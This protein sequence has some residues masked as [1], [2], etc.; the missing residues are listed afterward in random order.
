M[1]LTTFLITT[2]IIFAAPAMAQDAAPQTPPAQG[3]QADKPKGGGDS[4]GRPRRPRR[5][6]HPGA[7][8]N[9]GVEV[10]QPAPAF[11]LT[12]AD[13][14][15]YKL[16]DFAGK[17]VVLEWFCASCPVSGKGDSSHW[18]SGNAKKVLAGMKAADPNAVYLTINSTKSGHDGKSTEEH[19]KVSAEVIAA[20]GAEVPVLL[21]TDGTVGRAYGAKTTP[22]VFIVDPKGNV[23]YIG[24]PM[25]ADAETDYITS[26]VTAIKAGKPVEPS[27]TK[28]KGCSIKYAPAA[29]KPEKPDHPS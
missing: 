27:T 28:N 9:K 4:T 5:G 14:K 2:S 12:A 8:S 18:G 16:S 15:T 25:S 23:A 1:K 21:D 24:A 7:A 6:E 13:G 20:S 19:A 10:G 22:H 29:S 17:T 26:A 11:T 3:G